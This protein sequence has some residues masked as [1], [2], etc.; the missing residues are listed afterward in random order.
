M[1]AIPLKHEEIFY[2]DSDG[3]PFADSDL[4]RRVIMDLLHALDTRYA[5]DEGVYVS[6]DLLIYY[7]EGNPGASIAPDAFVVPGAG[8][9]LR[10][11]YKLWKERRVPVI[12]FEIISLTGW[13]KVLREKK[14]I[15]ERIGIEEYVVVAPDGDFVRPRLQGFR[16][17]DGR[18][19]PVPTEPD[20]SLVSRALGLR[21]APEGENLRLTDLVTG[22]RL[23]WAEE[24]AA[25]RKVAEERADHA[26]ERA[27]REAAARRTAEDE[28]ARLR[29]E[30]EN[31]RS[32]FR[33][34]SDEG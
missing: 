26:E 11:S 22:E 18:Y 16:L 32:R 10:R 30:L 20:G 21:I 5:G 34:T 6:G 27:D 23:L 28:I 7:I 1:S 13:K 24:E 3:Q 8:K 29:A 12:A 9:G 33:K 31:E 19:R 2:P 4:Q 14:D 17:V 25:A 15:Y